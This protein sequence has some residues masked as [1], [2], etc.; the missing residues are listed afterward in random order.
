MKNKNKFLTASVLFFFSSQNTWIL[1]FL[2]MPVWE[3]SRIT[4]WQ[5][6]LSKN[7]FCKHTFQ[8]FLYIPCIKN[9][10]QL[11]HWSFSF[12]I[13]RSF[14]FCKASLRENKDHILKRNIYIALEILRSVVEDIQNKKYWLAFCTLVC[15]KQKKYIYIFISKISNN[16]VSLSVQNSVS[17]NVL[18]HFL[19]KIHSG[20]TFERLIAHNIFTGFEWI[21]LTI[22]N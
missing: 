2:L 17:H 15:N 12:K 13:F 20:I 16:F 14:N 7:T 6:N 10:V 4:F 8:W 5:K 3:R 22:E 21:T 11:H 19:F 9:Y 18:L 1:L